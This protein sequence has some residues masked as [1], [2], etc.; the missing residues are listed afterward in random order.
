M[1]R[2][3]CSSVHNNRKRVRNCSLPRVIS[4][5]PFGFQGPVV[6]TSS[7]HGGVPRPGWVDEHPL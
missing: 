5:L 3:A 4:S 6:W 2:T 1:S 7:R